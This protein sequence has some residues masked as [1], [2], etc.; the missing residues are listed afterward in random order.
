MAIFFVIEFLC[1]KNPKT[2]KNFLSCSKK[3]IR[4]NIDYYTSKYLIFSAVGYIDKSLSFTH[5][6]KIHFCFFPL[7]KSNSNKQLDS[8]LFVIPATG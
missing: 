8:I 1:T 4:K 2:V 7:Y 3:N 5:E 6:K